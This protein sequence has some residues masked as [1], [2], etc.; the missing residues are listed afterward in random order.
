MPG[1]GGARPGAGRPKGS[2]DKRSEEF[3]REFEA[4]CK[5]Y[6]LDFVKGLVQLLMH[7]NDDIRLRAYNMALPYL[8]PKLQSVEVKPTD[9]KEPVF[10]LIV[11]KGDDE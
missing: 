11:E 7:E 1:T 4:A 10:K 6:G 9:I 3:K 5:Q 8:V 2:R